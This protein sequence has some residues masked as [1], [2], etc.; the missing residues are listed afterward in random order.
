MKSLLDSFKDKKFRFGGYATLMV[1]IVIAFLVGA[2]LLVDQLNFKADLTREKLYS[3]SEQTHAILDGLESDFQIYALYE[4]GRENSDIMEIVGKYEQRSPRISFETVDP[5]RSPGFAGKYEQDGEAPGKDSLILSAADN[6]KVISAFELINYSSANDPDDPFA[7]Q[8]QSLKAEQV[9]TGAI[10]S[11]TGGKTPVVYELEG[12]D[13]TPFPYEYQQA[14]ETENYIF[15]NLNLV[16]EEK[17]PDDA[18]IILIVSPELD[19]SEREEELLREFLFDRKGSAIFLMDL[20]P[21]GRPRFDS[22]FK[23]YGVAL[24]PV[25]VME[26]DANRHY[27]KIPYALVPEMT[28]HDTVYTLRQNDL[29]VF[30][31]R[32]QSIRELEIKKRTIEIEPLLTASDKSWG[33]I[34]LDSPHMEKKPED[35]SGPFNLAVAITDRGERQE[36]TGKAIIMGTSVFLYPDRVGLP[37]NLPGNANL[38]PNCFNWL[39]GKEELISIRPKSLRTIPLRL[40]SFQFYLYAGITI[41]LIPLLILG[42]G[43]VIWLKR[44]HL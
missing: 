34:D 16:T 22:L 43:L 38:L 1:A 32:S 19:L 37:I 21:G 3:L 26:G 42:S 15:K 5:Y 23:S 14:L 20:L 12:H 25:L 41:L 39:Q 11:L 40:S 27:P 8:A 36:E 9:L 4:T 10:I 30:F 29:Y 28:T 18:D 24:D 2:N 44:R 35:I 17:V 13:E 33:K 31:P 6:F 7:M